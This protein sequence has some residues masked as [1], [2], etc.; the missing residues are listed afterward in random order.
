MKAKHRHELKTNELAEWL[1][2]FPQWAKENLT[3]I[4]YVSVLI[5]V[6]AGIYIWRTYSKNVL[7]V[8]KQL[9]F[10]GLL[11][12]LSQSKAEILRARAQ[13]VDAS[14]ILLRPANNLK[15]FAQNTKDDIIAALALIEHAKALRAELH[16]R[17]GTVRER[18][19]TIQINQAKQSYNEALSRLTR[20]G[21]RKAT[22]PSLM[23][24]A[25]FGL[26]LCEEELGN[27]DQAR[28]IYR[29]LV[30]NPDFDATTAAAQAKLRLETMADYQEKLV[31]KAPPKPMPAKSIQPQ[32]QLKPTDINLVPQ[33]PQIV[34]K[35]V[36]VNLPEPNLSSQ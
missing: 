4:I 6:V 35:P 29:D 24:I 28:Q 12:R 3:T 22:N 11:A 8:Q 30:A 9:K 14:Y 1:M 26:G 21:A 23:A 18:E 33:I 27:F 7:S 32:I 36:D 5:A 16:Y 15:T 17:Q 20:H 31:F 13:G 25:T 2:N 34:L 10:T 19:L